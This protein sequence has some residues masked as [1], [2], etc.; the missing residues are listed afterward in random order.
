MQGRHR[1]RPTLNADG[2]TEGVEGRK[3]GGRKMRWS[4][5][6]ALGVSTIFL[7]PFFCQ[8]LVS[9]VAV[10]SGSVLSV[11]PRC[12][13]CNSL[14]RSERAEGRRDEVV[15]QRGGTEIGEGGSFSFFF[16]VLFLRFG[17]GRENEERE[18]GSGGGAFALNMPVTS[19][20]SGRGLPGGFRSWR[21]CSLRGCRPRRSARRRARARRGW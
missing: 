16:I 1:E 7:S 19:G 13:L 21:G 8:I 20:R 5:W 18:R 6:A 17:S 14:K 10:G 2:R 4:G 3:M 15:T 12:S 9:A 11:S